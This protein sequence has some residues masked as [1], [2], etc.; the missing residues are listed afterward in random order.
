MS[1]SSTR[2]RREN[3]GNRMRALVEQQ[4]QENASFGD[5]VLDDAEDYVVEAQD[6]VFD[7]DFGSTDEDE[8]QIDDEATVRAEEKAARQHVQKRLNTRLHRPKARATVSSALAMT[9]RPVISAKSST[10]GKP[11]PVAAR[12]KRKIALGDPMLHS[13]RQSNRS[14]TK[15][16]T[17]Q[18]QQKLVETTKRRALVPQRP[19]VVEVMLTQEQ[20]LSE[21]KET[22]QLNLASLDKIIQCEEEGKAKRATQKARVEGPLLRFRSFKWPI[23][24]ELHHEDVDVMEA[25]D[26]TSAPS[27]SPPPPLPLRSPAAAAPGSFAAQ[28]TLTFENFAEDPFVAYKNRPRRPQPH[29]CPITGLRARYR[30]PVLSV[31]YATKE[32]YATLKRLVGGEYAWSPICQAYIHPFDTQAP[33]GTP[34][35]W[36]NST[37][38]EVIPPP[39]SVADD[40]V[41]KAVTVVNGKPSKGKGKNQQMNAAHET[42]VVDTG[43]ASADT[44]VQV[45]Q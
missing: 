26:S 31:P 12:Q 27:P 21:A 36:V 23:I 4:M 13:V 18:L 39:T 14:S 32:A 9:N 33:A 41:G 34:D 30:D 44:I 5:D 22:E 40:L 8:E 16:A 10:A 2:A 15:A 38:G 35:K 20:K 42:V 17:Q 28:S 45:I 29:I 11:S 43:A 6:D 3:A 37:F 25:L 7:D 1:L 24:Q 19:R